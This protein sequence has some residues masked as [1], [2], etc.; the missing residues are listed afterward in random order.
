MHFVSLVLKN[1]G[2]RRFRSTFTVVGVA[3]A[4]GAVAALMGLSTGFEQVLVDMYRQ[5][6]IDLVVV[7]TGVTERLTSS[8]DARLEQTL[9]ALPDVRQAAPELLDVVS[10]EDVNLV[11][12][13]VYGWRPGSFVFD[14]LRLL[15]G[16]SLAPDAGRSVL[17]GTVLAKDLGKRVGDRVEVY[18]GVPFH[19]VGIFQSFNVYEN[20][21]MIVPLAQLQQLTNRRGRVTLFDLV[22]RD[23]TDSQAADRVI[24]RIDGLGRGLTAMTTGNYVSTSAQL[25]LGRAMAVFVST[26]ALVMGTLGVLNTMVMAVF[27]RTQEIGIL[28]AIGWRRGR[29]LRMILLE[30]VLLSLAGAV[31]GTLAAV[32][33]CRVLGHLP[34]AGGLISGQIPP[35]VIAACLALA[36]VLGLLGGLYPA[37]HG[38]R[39]TPTEALR[40]E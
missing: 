15:A 38:S 14:H 26:I 16:K 31:L 13:T 6:G 11:G 3:V 18:A 35:L 23:R 28:R 9:A 34:G 5:R 8:L 39:L 12:V 7:R 40:H 17:L 37:L 36:P 27:E 19:V 21:A 33:L 4:A 2:R 1:I 32:L 24:H 30:S 20:A 25:R 10:M 22:L 29:V